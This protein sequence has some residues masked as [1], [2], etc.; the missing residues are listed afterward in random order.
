MRWATYLIGGTHRVGLVLDGEIR[1]IAGVSRL[2]DLLGDDGELME[3]AAEQARRDPSEVIPVNSVQLAAPI[4]VPPSFRDFMAFEEHVVNTRKRTGAAV[5]PGWYDAPVFY[6][7]NPAAIHPP[8][9]EVA[10]PP[11]CTWFDYE[12]EVAAVIGRGGSDLHPDTAEQHIA[13]Y[14]VLADWSARDL[15]RQ[16]MPL[17]FGPVKG[18]DSATSIGP[19]LVTPDELEPYRSGRSYNL[20]MTATVNG[21]LYSEGNW[22][23]VYWSFAEMLAYASRGT[24]L[25]PGDVIGSGTV[26][27]GCILE[28]SIL[29]G[30]SEYPWLAAGDD[31]HLQIEALGAIDA[32]IV[33]GVAPI[34]LR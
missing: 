9:G 27:Q 31:V 29:H 19:W 10:I 17:R 32:H 3:R 5:D 11:G 14:L 12:L 4:P 1:G 30:E 26:G 18:K 22:S 6:F 21:R 20:A 33:P 25:V 28:L 7:S 15:Q 13:G 24:R 8:R 34:P 2:I 16:E 23:T